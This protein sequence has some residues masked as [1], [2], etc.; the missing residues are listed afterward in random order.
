[1][2]PRR[3][4]MTIIFIIL[5][6]LVLWVWWGNGAVRL[7]E[8]TIAHPDLPKS[9]SG[10]KIAHISD[11]H[12][13]ELGKDNEKVL[14]IL[15]EAQPDLIAITGDLIDSRRT[16]I[17][18][19]VNFVQQAVKIAPTYYATG[20]HE[21][22]IADYPK[23]EEA[24]VEAGV[25]VLRDEYRDIERDDEK[26][27]IIGLED[28]AFKK[29]T[30]DQTAQVL[31]SLGAAEGFSLVLAHRPELLDAYARAEAD[32]VLSG[33]AHGGQVRIPFIG[34]IIAPHQ[35]FFPELTEDLHE[36]NGTYL[37]IS[38]GLGNS[39]FPFRVNNRPEVVLITL[40]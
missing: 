33:H 24:M 13:A 1:M 29:H 12:N 34:G 32:V 11:L 26:I 19:S 40:E 39:L 3:K 23:L 36:E 14:K 35:G 10:M 6:L 22:R 27:R 4:K 8:H 38:R 16:D 31:S 17:A 30:S 7:A 25:I 15:R 20:N 21:S 5:A 28:P 18:T 2:K 9:F 37:V